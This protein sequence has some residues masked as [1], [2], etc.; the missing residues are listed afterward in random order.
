MGWTLEAEGDGSN[1]ELGLGKAILVLGSGTGMEGPGQKLAWGSVGSV[2]V[3]CERCF[4]RVR[5]PGSL[6]GSHGP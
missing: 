6:W 4:G 1:L 2:D 5:L 3:G